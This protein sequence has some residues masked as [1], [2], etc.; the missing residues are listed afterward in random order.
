MEKKAMAYQKYN[1]VAMAQMAIEILPKVASEI[2]KP[3]SS[4]DKITMIGD[5]GMD[6]V[7]GHVPLIMAKTMEAMKEATGVDLKEI[8]R[9][10]TFE[11]K[12]TQNHNIHLSADDK[13]T[14]MVSNLAGKLTGEKEETKEK[15]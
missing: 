5:G 6:H 12:T 11:G 7:S 1:R 15:D 10:E 9:A 4:I 3:L 2:A 13:T 8:M 14:Q